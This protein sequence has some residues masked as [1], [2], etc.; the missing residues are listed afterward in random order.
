MKAWFSAPSA[1]DAPSNDLNFIKTL[2]QYKT[3]NEDI[4]NKALKSFSGHLWYLS[5]EIVPLSLIS[6]KVVNY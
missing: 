6:N 4:T 5:P 3:L 1:L 2:V